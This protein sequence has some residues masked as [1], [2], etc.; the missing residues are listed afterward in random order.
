MVEGPGKGGGTD[1]TVNSEYTTEGLATDPGSG[2]P[3]AVLVVETDRVVSTEEL[4]VGE[5]GG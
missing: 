2:T 4:I 3:M 1:L 5:G